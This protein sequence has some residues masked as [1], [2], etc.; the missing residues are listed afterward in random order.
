MCFCGNVVS[1]VDYSGKYS[2]WTES[3]WSV[4]SFRIFLQPDPQ[5]DVKILVFGIVNTVVLTLLMFGLSRRAS[6]IFLI[7]AYPV[8]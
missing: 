6:D 8:S 1:S 2:T 7:P 3:Q 4:A 5:E